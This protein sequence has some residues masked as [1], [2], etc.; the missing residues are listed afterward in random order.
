MSAAQWQ[1]L[2]TEADALYRRAREARDAKRA[3]R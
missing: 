3:D 1:P 2:R